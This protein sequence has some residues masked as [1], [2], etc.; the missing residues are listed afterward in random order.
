[1][2]LFWHPPD[3]C[4]VQLSNVLDVY[5]IHQN[6]CT[7]LH[8][9]FTSTLHLYWQP[10]D[11][12]YS[13]TKQLTSIFCAKKLDLSPC[14]IYSNKYLTLDSLHRCTKIMFLTITWPF[15]LCFI[16]TVLGPFSTCCKFRNWQVVLGLKRW[17]IKYFDFGHK[18]AAGLHLTFFS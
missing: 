2:H 8:S 7:W 6:Y 13:F 10:L 3:Y 15:V 12:L 4:T 1:M 14:T 5:D 11:S 18:K 17:F 16:H 9:V